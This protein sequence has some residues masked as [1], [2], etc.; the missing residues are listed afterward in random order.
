MCRVHIQC[1]VQ[2]DVTSAG[3]KYALKVFCLCSL[4]YSVKVT[5]NLRFSR[6]FI[7]EFMVSGIQSVI[8][9]LSVIKRN[10]PYSTIS[11]LS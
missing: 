4:K 7:N 1:V 6:V 2:Y 9:L 11:L 5:V 8:E 10:G 3:E